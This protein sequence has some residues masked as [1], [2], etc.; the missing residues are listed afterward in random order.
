MR[1]NFFFF[2]S[3]AKSF[4]LQ[5]RENKSNLQEDEFWRFDHGV[6]HKLCQSGL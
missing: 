2:P 1:G 4:L 3:L 5:M 6:V